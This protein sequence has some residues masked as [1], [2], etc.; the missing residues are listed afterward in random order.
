[1]EAFILTAA[2]EDDDLCTFNVY[3]LDSPAMVHMVHVS[4]GLDVDYS[5]TGKSFVSASFDKSIWTLPV[6]KSL[7]HTENSACYLWDFPG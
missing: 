5:T 2:N 1:M 7:S 6:D 4:V 3:A